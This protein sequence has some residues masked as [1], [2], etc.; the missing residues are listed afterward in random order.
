VASVT[1][2]F[3]L[4]GVQAIHRSRCRERASR[5]WR[6]PLL[7]LP[8]V[9][10]IQ[11][12]LQRPVCLNS[13]WSRCPRWRVQLRFCYKDCSSTSH[14]FSACCM[15]Y[16]P[17]LP[18][19]G[20]PEWRKFR[21]TLLCIF[22]AVTRYLCPWNSAAVQKCSPVSGLTAIINEPLELGVWS[23]IRRKNQNCPQYWPRQQMHVSGQLNAPARR[24]TKVWVDNIAGLDFLLLQGIEPE[25]LGRP[26]RGLVSTS[27]SLFHAF[28]FRFNL[29]SL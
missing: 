7:G 5:I 1:K 26:V 21:G 20:R 25:S 16:P 14:L 2:S 8:R 22:C 4:K 28:Y 12:T 18:W 13:C 9:S 19:F 29:P 15:P 17:H 3:A 27:C 6:S 11:S 24:W 23:L 10:W